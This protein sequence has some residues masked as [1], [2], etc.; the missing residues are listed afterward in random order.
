MSIGAATSSIMN[1]EL[2][3]GRD[4]GLDRLGN[5]KTETKRIGL[6]TYVAG[7]GTI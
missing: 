1:A 2:S 4:Y 6:V 5:G 3:L 7:S